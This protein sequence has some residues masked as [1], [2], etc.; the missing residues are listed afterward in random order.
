MSSHQKRSR[1][2]NR[3]GN[4]TGWLLAALFFSG[5][6]LSI[7]QLSPAARVISWALPATYGIELVRDVTLRGSSLD[8]QVTAGL[9]VYGGVLVLVVLALTARQMSVRT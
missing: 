7:D 5:F 9:A 8:A 1:P 6:F 4:E 2:A 3:C